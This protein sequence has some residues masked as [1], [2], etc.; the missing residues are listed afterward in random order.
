MSNDLTEAVSIIAL[1]LKMSPQLLW[2]VRELEGEKGKRGKK[3]TKQISGPADEAEECVKS[4]ITALRHNKEQMAAVIVIST[5][6][7]WPSGRLM[8]S[9]PPQQGR[10]LGPFQMWLEYQTGDGGLKKAA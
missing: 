9:R 4:T 7:T 3:K 10:V 8:A 5:R 6:V 2:W 1:G